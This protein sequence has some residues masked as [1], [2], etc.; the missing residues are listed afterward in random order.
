MLHPSTALAYLAGVTKRVKLGTG[1]TPHRA[2]QSGGAG[3]RD[4]EPRCG[5]RGALA[6]RH[7]RRAICI[8]SSP[9][10]ACRSRNGVPARTNTS[11]PCGAL[12]NEERPSFPRPIRAI[13]RHPGHAAPGAGRRPAHRRRRRQR[14]GAQTFGGLR[15]RLV[16]LC[17]ECGADRWRAG[18]A[19]QAWRRRAGNQRHAVRAA[20][21]RDVGAI[22]RARRT[23]ID[24]PAAA[25]RSQ[26]V[27]AMAEMAELAD[28][29]P[30]G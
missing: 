19:A 22:C 8:R 9:R 24:R 13:R 5:V 7:R 18:A 16:R 14:R 25:G 20:E 30:L 21:R 28:L 11:P 4:G 3:Q 23:S 12:W 1:I 27:G 15:A 10:L 26:G 6:A 17:A 2:T 29:E